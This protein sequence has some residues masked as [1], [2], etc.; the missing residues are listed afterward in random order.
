MHKKQLP[1]EFYKLMEELQQV[2]FVLVELNLYLNT[3]PKDYNAVAQYN[4]FTQ[5]RKILKGKIE[6]KYGPLQNFG[7][8]YSG[9]PWQWADEPWPWQL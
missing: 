2:D 7:N 4:E 1:P 8:S 9:Y 5:K 3:H 6:S